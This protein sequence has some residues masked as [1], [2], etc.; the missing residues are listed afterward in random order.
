MDNE[1]VEAARPGTADS[2]ASS[3]ASRRQRCKDYTLKVIAFLFSNVGLVGLVTGYCVMGAFAFMALEEDEERRR[4][5][6]V[7][8]IR[9]GV[10]TKI[11]QQL[12]L[13]SAHDDN[14]EALVEE[15][16]KEFQGKLAVFMTGQGFDVNMEHT[17]WTFIGAMLFCITVVTTI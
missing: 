6:A 14:W 4:K 2:D 5:M 7:H 8:D 11:V 15:K 1:G 16:L 3:Y 12:R 9:V 17:Q 10:A 13:A